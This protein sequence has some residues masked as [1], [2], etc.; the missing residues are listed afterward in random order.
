MSATYGNLI[1]FINQPNF[2]DNDAIFLTGATGF[3]GGHFLF[4]KLQTPG[5][6]YVLVRASDADN[7]RQRIRDNLEVCARSYNLPMLADSVLNERLICVIGELKSSKLG[8]SEEQ[9][10]EL[11][12]AGIREVWHSAA[13]LSFRWED[14]DKIDATNL[15]GVENLL[16]LASMCDIPRIVYVSTAYTAGRKKGNISEDYHAEDTEFANYY[17]ASKCAAEK[18]VANYISEHG[19]KSTIVRPS[20]IVGPEST[21]CSGG[22]RFGLYGFCQEMY[23]M[24]D[25]LSQVKKTL[26]LVGDRDCLGNFI[27]VDHVVYDML[28]LKKIGFGDQTIYHA[29]NPNNIKILDVMKQ[30]EK[31][32]GIDC[33]DIVPVRDGKVSSFENLFDSKTKFYEGYYGTQKLFERS[34]PPHKKISLSDIDNYVRLFV[35]ELEA[36]KQGTIFDRTQVTSWDNQNITVNVIGDPAKTPIVIAN[37]Y[38]MPVD[39]VTPLARRLSHNHFVITWDTRWVPALTQAFELDKCNSLT[40][41][42]DLIAILD[43]FDLPKASIVGWSSGAQ[44]CL[45]TM[46]EF[47]ERIEACVLLNGGVSLKN[48]SDIPMTIFEEN[49]R[50]LL[51]KISSNRRMAEFY[52]QLIYG[53]QNANESD[54][55]AISSI[56]TST[57]PYLLYMTSMPFRTTESLFRYANMMNNLF[58]EPEDAYT[59]GVQT[60]T[61]VFG[62]DQD[63]VTHPLLAKALKQKLANAELVIEENAGHFAQF[64]DEKVAKM[65]SDFVNAKQHLTTQQVEAECL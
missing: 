44:V 37:A 50:S 59:T 1:E 21:Q 23:Q 46:Q 38:G 56:L 3:L 62:C 40:H 33:I 65:V 5:K 15:L 47:S 63:E 14:K 26:R 48:D 39:F 2:E 17:E 61:L 25:T 13:S 16:E 54:E 42:K 58:H 45:R 57:D 60:R 8:I 18:L 55:N 28:Y 51:P 64:Y 27:P 41:A 29:T 12:Q 11:A 49:L 52:C 32:N 7:A 6:V 36:E 31:H 34:L 20:I 30:C 9:I 35:E 43:H 22:T 24:R 53:N 4:W 19:M 10:A